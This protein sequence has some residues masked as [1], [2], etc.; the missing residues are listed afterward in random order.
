MFTN[1]VQGQKY[2]KKLITRK[3]KTIGILNM[4]RHHK[5]PVK[6]VRQLEFSDKSSETEGSVKA[7]EG[8]HHESQEE[9]GEDYMSEQYPPDNEKYKQ[10][11]DRLN[12]ME[13]LKMSGLNLDDLSLVPR[14][15]IP[16]KFKVPIFAKYDGISCLKLHLKSYVQKIQPHTDDRKLWIHYFQESLS[17]A[18]LEWYYQLEN[19]HIHTWND[20][21]DAFYK[22]YQYNAELAPTRMQLQSMSMGRDEKFKEYAQKW[23][24]LAGRVQPPFSNR[25]LV[26]MFMGT[27]TCPFFNH[28]IG[29]SSAGFTELIL[30]GERIEAGI[31]SGKIQVESSP[32]AAKRSFGGKK[33]A[34]AVYGQKSRGKTDRAQSGGAVVISNPTPAQPQRDNARNQNAPRRQFTN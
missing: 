12:A 6:V 33:E 5:G 18:Q 28:L 2:L 16:R 4:G 17:E 20:L 1:L 27:L 30:T 13:N 34:N 25:E 26:D 11:E 29:N 3:K 9:E 19:T 10:L 32:N 31:K 24:D 22:Q 21:A 15:V 23:R 14:V 8:S 7:N